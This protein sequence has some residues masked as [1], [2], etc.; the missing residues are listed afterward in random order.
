MRPTLTESIAAY[1]RHREPHISKEDSLAAALHATN[2]I[3]RHLK[4]YGED[5]AAEILTNHRFKPVSS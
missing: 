2:D 3:V 5:Q 4:S 1:I